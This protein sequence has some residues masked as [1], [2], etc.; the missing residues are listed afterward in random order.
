M[1]KL[2]HI[3]DEASVFGQPAGD[4]D[5]VGDILGDFENDIKSTDLSAPETEGIAL[6]LGGIAL[7]M[8]EIIKLLGKLVNLISKIP[9]LKKLSGDKLI[10]LGNKYHGKITR[11]FEF[12]IKK[13]GVK[14]PAK[15]KKFANILHHV[16]IAFLLVAGGLGMQ[17]LVASGQIKGSILKGA[18]NAIKAKELRAFIAASAEA[19]A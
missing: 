12:I 3:L 9:G 13:A 19:I 14:D 15:T 2:K 6:T 10:A 17:K 7:S 5:P 4:Q 18:M 16:V 1:I 8:P 11:A